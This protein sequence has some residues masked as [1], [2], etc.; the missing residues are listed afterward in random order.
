MIMYIKII[1]LVIV[2]G[3]KWFFMVIKILNHFSVYIMLWM[4]K[5]SLLGS[6]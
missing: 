1:I 4:C 2:K 5:F 3:E 6:D